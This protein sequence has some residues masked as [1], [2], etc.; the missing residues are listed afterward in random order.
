MVNT[1]VHYIDYDKI[2]HST[3]DNIIL[4]INQVILTAIFIATNER[5]FNLHRSLNSFPLTE[6]ANYGPLCILR[7]LFSLRYTLASH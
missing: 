6:Y 7:F 5:V 3:S 4:K 2:S 1:F